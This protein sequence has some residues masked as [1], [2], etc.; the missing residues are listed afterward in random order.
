M[1][2]LE[3]VREGLIKIES[4]VPSTLMC[5]QWAPSLRWIWLSEVH[6]A[7]SGSALAQCM[8]TLEMSMLNQVMI[9]PWRTTTGLLNEA[10]QVR[11]QPSID[12][13]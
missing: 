12:A 7:T 6:S 1:S 8:L 11:F 3:Y 13:E 10:S 5:K 4:L 2:T 9:S